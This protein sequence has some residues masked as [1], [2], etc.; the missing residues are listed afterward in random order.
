MMSVLADSPELRTKVALAC[1]ILAQRGL[2][3]GI[4][5]HVSARVADTE[6]LIRC[7]TADEPGLA[8]SGPGEVWRV[9][10]DGTPIDLPDGASAPNELPIHTEL[11]RR[12]EDVGCVIHAHPPF[13][14][15]S[16]L[17]GL[18]PRAVFGAYNIPAMRLALD[19]VPV[20]PRPILITRPELAAELIDVMAGRPVCLM[21]GHGI[22]V[23]APTVEQ[24]TVLAL[25]LNALLEVTVELARLGVEPPEVNSEDLAE[26][27][28]LG[29]SFN[30][31]LVWRA[32]VASLPELPRSRQ[33]VARG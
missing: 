19:G 22:T 14:L 13:A 16:G 10:F 3:D 18:R 15:L 31:L 23:A 21:V 20:Y 7:R 27:P 25:N 17:A 4:L 6:L 8:A 5:G 30:D 28:D 26:L 1:R 33:E 9:A 12:R 29:S 11:M 32:L 2:V 24:A